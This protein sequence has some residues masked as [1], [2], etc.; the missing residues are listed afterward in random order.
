M[1][2]RGVCCRRYG[3]RASL[4]AYFLSVT[5]FSPGR[6]R[7][8]RRSRR[9]GCARS[10]RHPDHQ[11]RRAKRRVRRRD[12]AVIIL[13]L[14]TPDA[15]KALVDV[16]DADNNEQAKL[17][18]CEA[19]AE[20]RIQVPEFLPKLESLLQHKSYPLRKAAATALGVYTDPKVASRLESF[21]Q[22]QERIL[23]T[24]SLDK[25]MDGLY[26]ATPDEAKRNALLL[27]WLKSPLAT[28]RL[29]ALQLVNDALRAKG[30]NPA[31]E[32]LA[33]IRGTLTDP[34]ELVRQ[35]TIDALRDVGL[36][37]D[38]T[39]I[40]ALLA[41]ERSP[42]VRE[43]I[44]KAL[45]KLTDP[46]SIE[47]CIGGMVEPDEKV[48]AAASDALGRL[49]QKG[50][51]RE[52]ER[53]TIV[54]NAIL[55]RLAR[56]V[57]NVS[58]RRELVEAMADIADPRFTPLLIRHAGADELEPTIRQAALRGLERVGDAAGLNIV[59]DRLAHDS[60]MGV[61]E[62]AAH[63]L[64]QLGDQPAH[65]Q[66]LRTRLD[67]TAETAPTV[68]N[69]AWDAYLLVFQKLSPE[70]QLA[71]LATWD[72]SEPERLVTLSAV[73]K[74]TIRATVA[75]NLLKYVETLDAGDHAAA[76][77]F[78]D[79][80]IKAVPDLFGKEWASRFNA[81]RK[82]RSPLS[83]SPAGNSPTSSRSVPEPFSRPEPS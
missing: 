80:L 78:L 56:P 9:G 54:V 53:I 14:G 33:Q 49:C 35:K 34:D 46:A 67:R 59:L 65:L 11:D 27:E 77:A 70:D 76:V 23:M 58:L 38:A 4:Q 39:R 69:A 81:V 21:R 55:R 71:A 31:T 79:Q 29:K 68:A 17:A 36:P 64:G 62:V 5:L 83:T 24:E 42:A 40:R 43:E 48:A 41:G 19:V 72:G 3:G 52:H 30:A 75:G 8:G 60:D 28:Q 74:P 10:D 2:T 12:A 61:R 7:W 47:A 16:F 45:G 50:S 22:E 57:E 44:Y 25:L 6:P 1:L 73:V 32:I 63:A 26:E 20:T 15:I 18:V 13:R 66:A 37:E 51:V 82:S